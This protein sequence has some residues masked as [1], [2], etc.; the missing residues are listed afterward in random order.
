[1][2][3]GRKDHHG[4]ACP[5]VM[6]RPVPFGSCGKI[7]ETETQLAAGTY[8]VAEDSSIAHIAKYASCE[9]ELGCKGVKRAWGGDT[10]DVG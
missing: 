7:S 8:C 1:M 2:R 5:Q 6:T 3:T 9:L 4:H 10:H